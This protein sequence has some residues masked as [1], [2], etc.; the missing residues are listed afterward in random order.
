[1]LTNFY[2]FIICYYFVIIH[3]NNIT[4]ISPEIIKST[5]DTIDTLNSST[6]QNNEIISTIETKKL[7]ANATIMRKGKGKVI[8]VGHIGS[9]NSMPNA[10]L[11]LDMAREE[12]WKDGILDDEFDVEIIQKRACGESFE[13]VA[14]A[15]DMFH[16]QNVKAFIGPYC[17]AEMDA[18]SKMATYWNVPIIGYMATSNIFSDKVIYKTLARVSIRTTNSLAVAV[19]AML[20]HY[21]WTNIAIVTNTGVIA[22]E[23][24]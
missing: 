3:S 8:K 18:V 1:M 7:S 5:H 11:I 17:T 13:G 6:N 23:V 21:H 2:V 10:E 12:L 24:T 22:L 16:I 20:K 9:T 14:V 4:T 19:A 15:A